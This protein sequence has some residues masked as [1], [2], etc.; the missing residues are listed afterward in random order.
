MRDPEAN[1]VD[2]DVDAGHKGKSRNG[3][4]MKPSAIGALKYGQY[5]SMETLKA[6]IEH[7][8]LLWGARET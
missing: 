1:M 2:T 8:Y 3:S 5:L 7:Q 4:R 6:E